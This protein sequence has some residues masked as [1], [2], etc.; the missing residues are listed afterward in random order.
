MVFG[1]FTRKSTAD[2]ASPESNTNDQST[3]LPTPTPTPSIASVV[4]NSPLRFSSAIRTVLRGSTTDLTLKD[5]DIATDNV[6]EGGSNF[7]SP[8][9]PP[10]V[11]PT[12]PPVGSDE[13]KALYD[14]M[15]AIPP[16]TLHAY[17]LAHLRP[18]LPLPLTFAS[19]PTPGL[20]PNNTPRPPSPNTITK[21]NIFFS[22]LAPPPSLHCVRCHKDFY[23]VENEEKDKA[24]RIPHD[25][26]SALVSRISG[27]G[28]E[29]LWGCCGQ[30][31]SGDGSEGPPDGWC[32][33]GR[34]TVSSFL[35]FSIRRYL[36][37]STAT[38]RTSSG[39]DS[40]RTQPSRTTS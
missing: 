38:R 35:P 4:H 36:T 19:S 9:P 28:Y 13:T 25:D 31:A 15:V 3:R 12:P 27:G 23:D 29:T 37:P 26:D 33:E 20:H 10:P 8:A 22:T 11:T 32:Y 16:K 5:S 21:M 2:D 14:L 18:Q 1:F 24:C 30:T 40:E 34:H 17:T 7:Y 39:L 6:A